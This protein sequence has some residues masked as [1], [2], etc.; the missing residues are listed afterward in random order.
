MEQN[1][2]GKDKITRW[3]QMIAKLKQKFIP[4]DYEFDLLKKMQG[5]KQVRIFFQEY[6]K[7]FYQVLIRT[8]HAKA[9]KEKV[10]H[11]LYGLRSSI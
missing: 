3:D 9:D 7:E 1:R 6:T 10:A 8:D 2:K 4:M 5:L 11:Y